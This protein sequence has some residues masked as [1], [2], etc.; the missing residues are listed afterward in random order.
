MAALRKP[1]KPKTP[2]SKAAAYQDSFQVVRL[3]DS[4]RPLP[5]KKAKCPIGP[6]FPYGSY[7]STVVRD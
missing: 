1:C 7:N 3:H 2:P 4:C 5:T 6:V